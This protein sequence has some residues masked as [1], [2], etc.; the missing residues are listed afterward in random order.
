[1]PGAQYEMKMFEFKE[2]RDRLEKLWTHGFINP[3]ILPYDTSV[4]FVQKGNSTW[5]CMDM[6]KQINRIVRTTTKAAAS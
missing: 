1:M 2:L 6:L 5:L 4:I 3:D